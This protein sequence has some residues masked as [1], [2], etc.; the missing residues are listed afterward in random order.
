MR[1]VTGAG[2]EQRVFT[3]MMTA[4][5]PPPGKSGKILA[6]FAKLQFHPAKVPSDFS[7]VKRKA[8]N[9]VKHLFCKRS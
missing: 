4:Y 9:P 8:S 7:V 5:I 3:E 6:N 1:A 2:Q